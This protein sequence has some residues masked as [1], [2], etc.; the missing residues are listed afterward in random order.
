[1]TTRL[2]G[3]KI[4]I[5]W[6]QLSQLTGFSPK[7]GTGIQVTPCFVKWLQQQGDKLCRFVLN[8]KEPFVIARK[9]GHWSC[10]GFYHKSIRSIYSLKH[11]YPGCR[12][13]FCLY[14]DIRELRIDLQN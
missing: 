11:L 9:R 5:C 4:S 10:R 6:Q 3:N 14:F 2:H 1:M 8:M 12:K 7:P 13:F